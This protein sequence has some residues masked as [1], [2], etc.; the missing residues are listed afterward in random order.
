MLRCVRCVHRAADVRRVVR[1]D[2]VR[3]GLIE[4]VIVPYRCNVSPCYGGCGLYGE[5]SMRTL[6]SRPLRGGIRWWTTPP[7][8]PSWPV[9]S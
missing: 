1:A 2:R 8:N 9:M 6:V 5:R 7:P 3:Y 4:I